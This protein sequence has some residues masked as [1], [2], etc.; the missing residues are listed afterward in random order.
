MSGVLRHD[1][2]EARLTKTSSTWSLLDRQELASST[3]ETNKQSPVVY[4]PCLDEKWRT[5]ESS[6]KTDVFWLNYRL[7]ICFA[8]HFLL[9]IVYIHVLHARF[10][11]YARSDLQTS[12]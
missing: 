9:D 4:T 7:A 2:V 10:A 8:V 5:S 6:D 12:R 11:A 1:A 3:A